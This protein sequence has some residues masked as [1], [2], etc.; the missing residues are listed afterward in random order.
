MASPKKERS[1]T[2][3]REPGF[4]INNKEELPLVTLTDAITAYNNLI[5]S[6]EKHVLELQTILLPI[7]NDEPLKIGITEIKPCVSSKTTRDVLGINNMLE[8]IINIIYDTKTNIG[9]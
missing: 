6:L 7:L 5:I 1:L 4:E 3:Y 9:I 2:E 8:R